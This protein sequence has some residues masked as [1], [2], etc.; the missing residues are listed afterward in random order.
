GKE[1][2]E[3]EEEGEAGG[4][5]RPD[6]PVLPLTSFLSPHCTRHSSPLMRR[7]ALSIIG[8]LGAL[9]L[10]CADTLR[11]RA[12]IPWSEYQERQLREKVEEEQRLLADEDIASFSHSLKSPIPASEGVLKPFP[13]SMMKSLQ[14]QIDEGIPAYS[15]GSV[16]NKVMQSLKK[17]RL[18]SPS[19]QSVIR[20]QLRTRRPD[21]PRAFLKK[22]V[23]KEIDPPHY[24][25]PLSR[26]PFAMVDASRPAHLPRGAIN[27]IERQVLPSSL[28]TSHL[29]RTTRRQSLPDLQP[30]QFASNT[31]A[32]PF[33]TDEEQP[34]LSRSPFTSVSSNLAPSYSRLGP[35][36]GLILGNGN[37]Q[38]NIVNSIFSQSQAHGVVNEIPMGGI[39]H[40]IPTLPQPPQIP[41]FPTDFLSAAGLPPAPQ[42]GGLPNIFQTAGLPGLPTHGFS[43]ADNGVV[44]GAGPRSPLEGLLAHGSP[45][46]SLGKMAKNFLGGSNGGGGGNIMDLM[47][48]ALSGVGKS[49]SIGTAS[50]IDPPVMTQRSEPNLMDKLFQSAAN[51]LSDGMKAKERQDKFDAMKR[52]EEEKERARETEEK[53]KQK[54]ARM[55]KDVQSSLKLLDGLPPDQRTLLEEALNNGEIDSDALAPAIKSL[56]KDDTKEDSQKEKVDRLI[57]WIKANRPRKSAVVPVSTGDKLPYYGKYCGSLAAQEGSTKRPTRPSG[58]IWAVDKD[59]FIVSKF[60][61]QPSSLNDNVTFWLGPDHS[62]LDLVA[63]SFPSDNGFILQPEPIDINVFVVADLKPVPARARNESEKIQPISLFGNSLKVKRDAPIHIDR[64]ELPP[65]EKNKEEVRLVVAQ[66][67]AVKVQNGDVNETKFRS[68]MTVPMNGLPPTDMSLFNHIVPRGFELRPAYLAQEDLSGPRALDWFA[69]FQPLLL[70]LPA[71]RSVKSVNWISL[72]DHKHKE[73]IASVIMPN[74]HGFTIPA[75]TTLRPLTPNGLFNISS[76]PIKVHDYKTIEITDFVLKTEGRAVWFMIGTDILPNASGFIAPIWKKST[77]SFDCDSLRDYNG[78]TLTIRLPGKKD[79]NDVFWLSVFSIPSTLSYSH[80]YLP[81]N[82]MVIPPDLSAIATPECVY[83]P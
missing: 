83:T 57:D 30:I 1:E 23:P 28:H 16:N 43:G 66:G 42:G 68:S 14:R 72:R 53:E 44:A 7:A 18:S 6:G 38:S 80:I 37:G 3:R 69:G 61:F 56:V 21:D 63:D 62:T 60:Q 76:G 67:G 27:A 10:I 25:P 48:N 33:E 78:E 51:A 41:Q 70:R 35:A 32:R 13:D 77:N 34:S 26:P 15:T 17:P 65:M 79:I 36:P 19:G 74:G 75:M 29:G 49:N 82:E 8:A 5:G 64:D 22:K 2:R 20:P 4:G 47:T 31:L 39:P 59:R 24:N 81:Y 73:T 50:A 46:E 45:F 9:S 40:G 52:E 71:D 58:A 12:I 54:Q 11:P 55:S